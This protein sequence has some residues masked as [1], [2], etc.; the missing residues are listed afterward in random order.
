MVAPSPCSQGAPA[1]AGASGRQPSAAPAR[2]AAPPI[3]RREQAWRERLPAVGQGAQREGVLAMPSSHGADDDDG[4]DA[5][6]RRTHGTE[7][8][9]RVEEN[10]FP[11][12]PG[13]RRA[14]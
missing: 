11:S 12:R 7:G 1:P 2:G 4:D 10:I 9:A 5:V 3:Y 14:A 13:Q 8:A 6:S